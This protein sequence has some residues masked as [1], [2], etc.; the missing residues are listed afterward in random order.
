VSDLK[1]PTIKGNS[2]F[3]IADLNWVCR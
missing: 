1:Q 3:H 2:A